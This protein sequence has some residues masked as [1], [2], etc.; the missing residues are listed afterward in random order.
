M[1]KSRA[2]RELV[3][4]KPAQLPLEEV[5]AARVLSRVHTKAAEQTRQPQTMTPVTSCDDQLS[6]PQSSVYIYVMVVNFSHEEIELPK[7][8]V[9]GVAEISASAVAAFND[10][11]ISDNSSHGQKTCCRVN[12]VVNDPSFK[13][14][15]QDKLGHLTPAERSVM[16][17]ILL[18]Y[19]H[20]FHEEGSNDF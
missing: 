3:C 7:A 14:F 8:T 1:P 16:E 18:K 13:Q 4:V 10:G 5:L 20:V 9:L 17:P 11:E 12:T 6:G 15:L 19:R 2:S